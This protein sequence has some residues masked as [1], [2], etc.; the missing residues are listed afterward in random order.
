[1]ADGNRISVTASEK[2]LALA[3]VFWFGSAGVTVEGLDNLKSSVSG[4]V[5]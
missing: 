4:V 1:L 5:L 3:A 2:K